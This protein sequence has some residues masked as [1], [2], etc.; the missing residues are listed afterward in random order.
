MMNMSSLKVY[1]WGEASFEDNCTFVERIITPI[2]DKE[3]IWD[4]EPVWDEEPLRS[5][6]L[7]SSLL[8]VPMI[9]NE[10]RQTF[11]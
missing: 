6:C 11:D 10:E 7:I 5:N 4:E 2:W 3:P 1:D 8:Y 9:L